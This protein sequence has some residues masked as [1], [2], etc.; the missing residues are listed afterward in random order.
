MRE[1]AM[2]PSLKTPVI[3]EEPRLAAGREPANG[4]AASLSAPHVALCK[5][6]KSF[7]AVRALA[8]LSLQ[9]DKGEFLSLLGPSGCGKTTLLRLIAGLEVPDSGTITIGE[10]VVA[11]SSWVQPERRGVG[12]VFQ[13]YALFPHMTVFDNV[14]FGV[15][16][17]N[18]P[19][20]G[21]KTMD[22][23][24]LVGLAELGG[25]YPH[26]LS[27]G[28]QQRVALARALAPGPAVILLDEPFS[29]L[30]VSLR[31]RVRD[32]IKEILTR[33]GATVILVTHDQEEALVM[34]DRIGVLNAGQLEQIDRPEVIFHRPATPFV[35]QFIGIADLL[36]GEIQN[37]S[38]VTELGRLPLREGL[39]AG[40]KVKA[41]L[42]PDSTEIYPDADGV[43]VV[44]DRVFQGLHYLYRVRLRS[45]ITIRSVQ[46]HSRSYALG[47]RVAV[48]LAR[49]D[50]DHEAVY[51]IEH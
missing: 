28:Q 46:H 2:L 50:Y 33:A 41:V 30:D 42:R 9:V 34:G 26:E 27:G 43:G 5:V 14:A 22:A 45:G 17:S 20:V 32:E 24:R 51:F 31:A 44:L 15:R 36:P 4:V 10:K 21:K 25:R 38:I 18:R 1:N 16:C 6:S 48:T 3:T 39:P 12:I 11:G 29:N 7:G 23:L 49:H 37:R 8:N 35:A 40:T 13:D 19:V 47:T